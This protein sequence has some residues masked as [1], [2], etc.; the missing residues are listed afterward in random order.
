MDVFLDLLKN[1]WDFFTKPQ[2]SFLYSLLIVFIPISS[3]SFLRRWL[4]FN[5]F[6]ERHEGFFFSVII[7]ALVFICYRWLEDRD[8]RKQARRIYDE[9]RKE[10]EQL[11]LKLPPSETALLKSMLQQTSSV[12]WIWIKDEAC[13]GLTSKRII[14]CVSEGQ[15]PRNMEVPQSHYLEPHQAFV[16][17]PEFLSTI[18][19]LTVSRLGGE[20]KP[21]SKE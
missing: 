5:S 6:F 16:I 19:D 10:R 13:L 18:L 21:I 12:S 20:Y 2:K 7:Y 15:E 11:L 1:G 4:G 9:Q 17:V 8:K 14:N 3:F